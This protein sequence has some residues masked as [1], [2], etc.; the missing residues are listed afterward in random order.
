MEI[1]SLRT[2]IL[3]GFTEAIKY[4]HGKHK[5]PPSDEMMRWLNTHIATKDLLPPPPP[6]EMVMSAEE[7][8]ELAEMRKATVERLVRQR[9]LGLE[10]RAKKW[11][12]LY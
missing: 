4:V 11:P 10:Q 1:Y 8:V 7:T 9:E 5:G 6:M 2:A 12:R 3:I